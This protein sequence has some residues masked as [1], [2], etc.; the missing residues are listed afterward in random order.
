MTS[1]P[2]SARPGIRT[3]LLVGM[4][5]LMITA[6]GF[7]LLFSAGPRLIESLLAKS[8]PEATGRMISKDIVEVYDDSFSF[9]SNSKRFFEVHV[10]YQYEAAG[11]SH[12]GTR[13]GVWNEDF[14]LP[15]A[16]EV[17]NAYYPGQALTVYYRPSDPAH[18]L[19]DRTVG[20]GTWFMV[21]A[22]IPISLLGVVMLVGFVRAARR[23]PVDFSMNIF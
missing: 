12:R 4:I 17:G 13:I 6:G 22:G 7:F 14:Q 21:C 19:L 23:G 16:K 11:R 15:R 5:P 3:T 2:P 20:G 1:P 8:W 9:S 10:V 18:S